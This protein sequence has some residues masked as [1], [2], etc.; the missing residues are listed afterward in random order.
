MTKF[1]DAGLDPGE[2]EFLQSILDNWRIQNGCAETSFDAEIA[3]G[4]ILSLFTEGF[5]TRT[6]IEIALAQ[7]K[8]LNDLLIKAGTSLGSGRSGAES[9]SDPSSAS[10][11]R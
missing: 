3:K 1:S 5:K 2:L 7:H 4:P 11:S 10:G 6:A 9:T 8:G